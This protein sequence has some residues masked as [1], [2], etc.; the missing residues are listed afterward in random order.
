MTGE[1]DCFEA[2]VRRAFAR[3]TEHDLPA[4]A[5]ARDWPVRTAEAFRRLLLDHLEG[6][7][8][9]DGAP[10]V[11]DLVLAVELGQRMLA[12][13]LCCVTM[14]RQRGCPES[15]HDPRRAAAW[16]ALIGVIDEANRARDLG[17]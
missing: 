17:R 10:C 4:A 9:P 1:G 11:V 2:A 13:D 12:G 15:Q 7:P 14:T 5:A 3:L 8:R 16:R 6:A